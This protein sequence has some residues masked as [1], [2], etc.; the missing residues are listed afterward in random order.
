VSPATS[1]SAAEYAVL[2][3]AAVADVARRG[4]LPVVVGGT[5]LY[6]RALLHGLFDGPSRDEPLRARLSAIGDRRGDERLHRLL[7]RV[8]PAAGSRIAP[9]DRVRV[10]RALEVYFRTGRPISEEQR[11]GASPLTGFRV[12]VIGLDPGR[13]ALRE[14]VAARTRRMMERGL[15]AEVQALLAAGV[16]ADARPLRSIGYRQALAVL[17]GEMT[18]PEAERAIVTE[19]LRFARRQRTWFRHQE[20]GLRWFAD[21]DSAY[22]AALDWLEGLAFP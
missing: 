13:D 22:A 19:T 10:V 21:A 1:F 3:R 11:A 20:P 9:S 6:L 2:A 7:R 16:P 17:R 8:D 12:L 18:E 4:R 15:V 14:A 5:G